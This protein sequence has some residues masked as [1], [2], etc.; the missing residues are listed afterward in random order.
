MVI[1]QKMI[2]NLI[3]RDETAFEYVYHQT[4]RGVYAIMFA[5]VK[6]HQVTEDLMQD[7]YM[8]MMT[9]LDQYQKN[10]KFYQWLL[11][12]ARNV[13]L[14]YYRKYRKQIHVDEKDF[15]QTYM[16]HEHLPDEET[17]FNQL[18]AMLS[19]EERTI[20]YLKV[21]DDM[22]HKDIAKLLDKPVGTI[23]YMYHEAIEKMKR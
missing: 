12:M 5:I 16:S 21:V 3:K 6:S 7:V 19:E 23:Q 10:T 14:D 9:S 13:A 2:N 18:T 1:E 15:D 20:V 22:K 8:K 4:K 17:K 11:Q